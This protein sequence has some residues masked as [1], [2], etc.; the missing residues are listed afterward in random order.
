[1]TMSEAAADHRRSLLSFHRPPYESWVFSIILSSSQLSC[2]LYFFTCFPHHSPHI[3]FPRILI[4]PSPTKYH[5]I[6]A[7]LSAPVSPSVLLR[8]PPRF[9]PPPALPI[10]HPDSKLRRQPFPS[11]AILHI[12]IFPLHNH[13]LPSSPLLLVRLPGSVYITR[14][15]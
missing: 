15:I 1:M 13:A 12:Y 5:P 8:P 9:S 14:R 11:I 2:F 6:S 10:H 3:A 7:T 4:P